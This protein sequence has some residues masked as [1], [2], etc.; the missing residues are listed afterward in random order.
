[1]TQPVNVAPAGGFDMPVG[2][3]KGNGTGGAKGVQGVVASAGFGNGTAIAGGVRNGG[4]VQQG[5]FAD[6]RATNGPHV[7]KTS[8]ATPHQEGP[9][10]LFK[11]KPEYTA[12]GRQL[13][14]QGDVLLQ[15]IFKASGE[16]QVVRV[17]QGLGHGLDEAATRAA[18][19]IK[20]KPALSN[21]HPVDFPAVV[22]IVFQI[23][24]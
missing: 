8:D 15:V 22:H 13:K 7:Q 23:A 6:D 3:G 14:I 12:E 1:M 18:Q 5:V 4:K 10:I 20:Y 2:P 21:G 19:Q 9:V 24:Y 17:V 11:P 16:V